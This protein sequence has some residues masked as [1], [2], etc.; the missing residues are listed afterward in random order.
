M[1]PDLFP[2]DPRPAGPGIVA[3]AADGR[4]AYWLI[5]HPDWQRIAARHAEEIKGTGK[6]LP[7]NSLRPIRAEDLG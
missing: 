4:D 7:E 5:A 3:P 1:T 6:M 2:L